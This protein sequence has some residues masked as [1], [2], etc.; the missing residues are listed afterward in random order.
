MEYLDARGECGPNADDRV[1]G[2]GHDHTT[3]RAE[4]LRQLGIER[5]MVVLRHHLFRLVEHSAVVVPELLGDPGQVLLEHWAQDGAAVGAGETF[6]R[7]G[8]GVLRCHVYLGY[9]V[10]RAGQAAIAPSTA[11]IKAFRDAPSPARIARPCR[12]VA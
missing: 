9:P 8:A 2:S 10:V 12:T 6:N 11:A 1:A 7:P 5:S 3:P 4:H